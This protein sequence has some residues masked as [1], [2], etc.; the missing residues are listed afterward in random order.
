MQKKKKKLSKR[1]SENEFQLAYIIK[2]NPCLNFF[3]FL[4]LTFF[5]AQ[6]MTH[7]ATLCRTKLK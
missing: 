3:E 4:T 1:P 5:F 6:K 2:T 7:K